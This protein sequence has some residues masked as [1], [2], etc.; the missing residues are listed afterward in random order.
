MELWKRDAAMENVERRLSSTMVTV[1]VKKMPLKYIL[2]SVFT[3]IG[4]FSLKNILLRV[5]Y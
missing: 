3:V 2:N 4:Y 5:H 1:V